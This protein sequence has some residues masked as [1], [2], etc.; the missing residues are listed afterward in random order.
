MGKKKYE[1]HFEIRL[2]TKY[3]NQIILCRDGENNKGK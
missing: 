3:E 1:H 2:A